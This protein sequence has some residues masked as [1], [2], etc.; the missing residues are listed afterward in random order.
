MVKPIIKESKD[1]TVDELRELNEICRAINSQFP[2]NH[3]Q[4]N[5]IRKTNPIFYLFKVKGKIVA[6]HAF[7]IFKEKTPFAKKKIPIVYINLSF[8]KQN[9]DSHIKN[10]AKWSNAHFLKNN[11]SRFWYFK[12]F[13]LIFLTNNPKLVERS[14]DVFYKSY[15]SY[16]NEPPAK[17][18][19]F[20]S[21]FTLQN[22][23]LVD[24][25]INNNL[26]L[27]HETQY[28]MDISSKWD[29][30]YKSYDFEQNKFFIQEKIITSE[31]NKYF[32]TGS[33]MLFVGHSSFLNLIKNVLYLKWKKDKTPYKLK[34]NTI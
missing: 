17:I 2:E 24:S 7:S 32:L 27:K 1:L 31:D 6:F 12:K 11:V 9:A 20:C 30:L 13:I 33:L 21:N 8:K 10:Y 23:K 16:T 25:K 15:P 28:K 22:L 5:H 3:V 18:Q 29:E 14:S 34:K 19:S 4:E 26:V